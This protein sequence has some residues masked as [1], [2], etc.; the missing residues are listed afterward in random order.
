ML[1]GV[2]IIADQIENQSGSDVQL[3]WCFSDL[4]LEGGAGKLSERSY[5][6]FQPVGIFHLDLSA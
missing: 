1:H 3:L 4:V 2:E 5:E 6:I